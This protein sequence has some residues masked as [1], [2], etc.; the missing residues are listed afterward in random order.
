VDI[1]LFLGIIVGFF[2]VLCGFRLEGGSFKA[3]FLF[4]P[5]LIVIGGTVGTIIS[6]F[7]F[8][9]II[10]AFKSLFKSFKAKPLDNASVII[11]KISE[12]S[13]AYKRGGTRGLE[14]AINNAEF[15]GDEYL[16]LKAGI[17]LIQESRT[18]EEIQYILES[19]IRAFTLQRQIEISVFEGAGG[20]SPTL[21][22]IGT[23]MALVVV[24][25]A[26]FSNVE[27]LTE[28]IATAFIATLYGIALANLAYLPMANRLKTILKRQRIHKEMILDGVCMI[29]KGEMPRNVQ[30]K[31]ALYYQAFPDGRKKYKEG[32]EN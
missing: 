8:K 18:T 11:E 28:S 13:E 6:S 5:A 25:A 10:Q 27:K 9:D 29:S 22:I 32:V 7:S 26:G 21:G 16:M 31:L 17:I 19:D 15:D 4:S 30:N 3:L 23:V 2:C 24:L 20:F 12:L 1:S 14:E